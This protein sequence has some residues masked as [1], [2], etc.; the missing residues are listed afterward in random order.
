MDSKPSKRAVV[1]GV[2]ITVSIAVLVYVVTD[3]QLLLEVVAV[4]IGIVI[5]LQIEMLARIERRSSREDRYS[6]VMAA[7]ESVPWLAP[8]LEEIA[9]AT[10]RVA[11]QPELRPL[12]D[13]AEKE[14]EHSKEN[15][16][17]LRHGKFRADAADT[18]ILFEET[19][20]AERRMMATFLQRFDLEWWSSEL[21]RHYWEVNRRAADRGVE[22]QRVFIYDEWTPELERIVRAQSQAGVDVMVVER[23]LLPRDCRIGMVIWD[24]RLVYQGELNSDGETINVLY[25][26]SK[27]DVDTRLDQFARITRYAKPAADVMALRSPALHGD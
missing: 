12:L 14:L 26:V 27:A 3:E 18:T 21:G 8:A 7:A 22:I 16:A 5:A 11:S 10:S 17:A 19:D 2:A 4:L 20:R 24:D 6:R 15:L 25:S 9:E 23:D 13:V 1:L